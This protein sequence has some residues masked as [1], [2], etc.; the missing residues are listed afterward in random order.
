MLME[1]TLTQPELGILYVEMSAPLGFQQCLNH[2][3]LHDEDALEL[4]RIIADQKPDTAL[5]S[6][7]LCGIILANHLLGKGLDDKDLNVLATELKYFSIDVVERYGRAW[8]NAREHDKHDRD[9]EEEL[10]LENA[11][12]LNAFGSIVQEIHESC[13]GP[14][15]LARALGQV[16]EYQAYAQANIAESYV[17]ILKHQG[18]IRKDFSGDPIPAPHNLQ[19]QDRY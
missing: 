10:L 9:I 19:P 3:Q 1:K 13:D 16:L 7:G 5:I 2:G 14:L 8:I 15:A 12:N 11:E 4:H 17:E 6:L 18:H